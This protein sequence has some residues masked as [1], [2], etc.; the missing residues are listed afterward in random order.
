MTDVVTTQ[1]LPLSRTVLLV[2]LTLVVASCGQPATSDSFSEQSSLVGLRTIALKIYADRDVPPLPG[3]GAFVSA[4]EAA[5]R[6]RF[7]SGGFE[8][9]PAEQAEALIEAH[10]YVQCDP[11]APVCGHHTRLE[12]KQVVRI[13][14]LRASRGFATTWQNSYTGGIQ[15]VALPT[16]PDLLIVNINALAAGLVDR[17]RV[18]NGR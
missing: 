16:L 6:G 4:A 5:I 7:E 10:F 15:A 2:A 11:F 17:Y 14:L 3:G 8:V 18:A 1:T 9:V 13:D 12:L